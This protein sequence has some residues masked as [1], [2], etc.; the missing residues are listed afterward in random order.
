MKRPSF[1]DFAIAYANRGWQVFPVEPSGKRPS[2]LVPHGLHNATS[3]ERQLRSWWKLE[4]QANV[5]IRT[6]VESGLVVLDVDRPDGIAVF[7]ALAE[8][9][10]QFQAAWATT[11]SGGWHAYL[12]HPGQEIRNSAGKLGRGIDVR[13]DGGYVVAPPS[14]HS[15][16]RL[17]A[18]R[19]ALPAELPAM[20]DWLT[21]RLTERSTLPTVEP[22]NADRGVHTLAPY[23]R[24]AVAREAADMAASQ[25]GHRNHRLNAAAFS[26]GQLVGAGLISQDTVAE[27]LLNAARVA[28]LSEREALRTID[29]GLRAGRAQPRTLTPAAPGRYDDPKGLD[30]GGR[31]EREIHR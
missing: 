31:A 29:S 18:W 2:R 23:A 20:P 26:L 9:H 5:G 3:E 27:Q 24:A 28:G 6:G 4:P 10:G 14:R 21:E 7:R 22:T 15:T 1:R 11:G 16:G 17:Y 19:R 25:V 30:V 8:A 13:G 12:A